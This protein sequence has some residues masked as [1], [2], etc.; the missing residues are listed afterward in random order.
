MAYELLG[1]S[2]GLRSNPHLKFDP[3]SG[4]V[5]D[6]DDGQRVCIPFDDGTGESERDSVDGKSDDL[7][8]LDVKE[9]LRVYAITLSEAGG[10]DDIDGND[11]KYY[12]YR[13]FF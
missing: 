12:H 6:N 10:G 5:F 4:L 1:H 2:V 9:F 7:E 3:I 13:Y 8:G 11:E